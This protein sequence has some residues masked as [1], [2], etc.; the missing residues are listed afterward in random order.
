LLVTPTAE[1]QT[2][3]GVDGTPAAVV[4]DATRMV[5]GGP[6]AGADEIRTLVRGS[7]AALSGGSVATAAPKHVH[8]IEPRPLDIGDLAPDVTV[9]DAS[10]RRIQLA[11]RLAGGK[12]ILF[13]DSM[14]GFCELL[15]PDLAAWEQEV[16]DPPLIVVSR[17]PVGTPLS[18]E[19]VT[20]YDPSNAAAAAF[21]SPGTPSA[22]RVDHE[23]KI[24]SGMAAGGPEVMVLLGQSVDRV[25]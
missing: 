16:G 21:G 19:A 15:A 7:V 12:V 13:W 6:A 25:P 18:L 3:Y 5:V 22:V 11:E 17:D 23:G 14:C 8:Q 9:Q 2:D 10:G 1:L 24:A 20:V 4:V